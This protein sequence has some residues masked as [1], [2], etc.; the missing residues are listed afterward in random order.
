VQNR[1]GKGLKKMAAIY[2]HL[3]QALNLL[4]YWISDSHKSYRLPSVRQTIIST[5]PISRPMILYSAYIYKI[6]EY[7]IENI[8]NGSEEGF[9]KY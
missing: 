8:P 5:F 6:Y 2:C 7:I 1:K 4:D 9:E 3:L